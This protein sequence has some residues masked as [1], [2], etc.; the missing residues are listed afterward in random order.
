[1]TKRTMNDLLNIMRRL[2]DPETGCPWDVEQDFSS[3]APYT[4]EEAYE[5]ADAIERGDLEDLCDEL[6]DLLLQVVFHA[7]MADEAGAFDF[8][9]VVESI[10]DK[11]VRRHPGVFTDEEVATAEE[12]LRTW[13]RLK[14]GERRAK[15]LRS[16]LDGVPRGM[17][18]LQRS[19]K[20]QKRAGEVGFEWPS[21]E[22]VLD[23][24][25]EEIE[26][27]REALHSG[28]RDRMQD[29]LGDVLFLAANLARQMELDP[30]AALRHANG[31]FDRRFRA[32]EQAAGGTEALRDMEV[33]EMEALWQQ[34][35]RG[36]DLS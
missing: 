14:A 17:A 11:L 27:L 30:A 32:M 20:I 16:A 25:A 24:F 13:D 26:E 1:M 31:K 33:D 35:K 18:E 9:D 6:G 8:S 4:V 29:E 22:P 34:I 23:R 5:V 3:I 36:Q 12:Q 7:Q 28:N 15:G 2:R 19:V 21:A 10:S